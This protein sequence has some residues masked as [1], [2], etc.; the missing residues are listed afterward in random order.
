MEFV[1]I[2]Y[3]IKQCQVSYAVTIPDDNNNNII[4]LKEKFIKYVNG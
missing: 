3:M 2:Q 4:A 1:V